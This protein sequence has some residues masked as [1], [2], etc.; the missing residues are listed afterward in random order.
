MNQFF[1]QPPRGSP[2][3]PELPP[4]RNEERRIL[5]LRSATNS[6]MD[7]PK[8]RPLD[9]LYHNNIGRIKSFGK[10]FSKILMFAAKT[11]LSCTQFLAQRFQ[12]P[13]NAN[14]KTLLY[15]FTLTPAQHRTVG[16]LICRQFSDILGTEISKVP[17]WVLC[18]ADRSGIFYADLQADFH[19]ITRD[20]H[21]V[22]P[23]QCAK[24]DFGN[25]LRAEKIE[26]HVLCNKSYIASV[27]RWL[28]L[29]IAEAWFRD[30][31]EL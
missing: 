30:E 6:S 3:T 12:K 14:D 26:G 28:P 13:I 1:F 24:I 16:Q 23:S 20:F 27:P 8:P 29:V 15:S 10:F 22:V 21:V 5:P 18:T 31:S 2:G 7:S 11:L 9:S 17:Y 25:G 19:G 4:E